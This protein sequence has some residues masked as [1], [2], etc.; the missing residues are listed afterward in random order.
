MSVCVLLKRPGSKHV[1]LNLETSALRIQ[2][3]ALLPRRR[4]RPFGLKCGRLINE[5]SS[6]RLK[7]VRDNRNE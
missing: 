1:T 3:G 5:V 7:R 2:M 4:T 6:L